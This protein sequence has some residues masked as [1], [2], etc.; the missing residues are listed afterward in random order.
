MTAPTTTADLRRQ[1][2]AA[3]NLQVRRTPSGY[4]ARGSGAPCGPRDLIARDE[5]ELRAVLTNWL[6]GTR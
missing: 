3:L 6:E 5:A 2:L 1:A 4:T